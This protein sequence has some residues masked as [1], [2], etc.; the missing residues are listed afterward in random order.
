MDRITHLQALATQL[1]QFARGDEILDR[2]SRKGSNI[3][4]PQDTS[5]I[6]SRTIRKAVGP[7]TDPLPMSHQHFN[8]NYASDLLT[9]NRNALAG[10]IRE[11]RNSSAA[12]N[13]HSVFQRDLEDPA[14][15]RV[16]R[17]IR[18]A[19][20]AKQRVSPNARRMID[21]LKLRK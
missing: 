12:N 14:G 3:E 9:V 20:L 4:V 1:V 5:S 15:T 16:K 6:F 13:H 17:A 8:P 2:V 19:E 7:E 10:E 11:Q 18:R 21:F